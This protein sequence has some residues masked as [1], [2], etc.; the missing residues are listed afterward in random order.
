MAQ[1]KPEKSLKLIER[2]I[3]LLIMSSSEMHPMTLLMRFISGFLYWLAGYHEKALEI[4]EQVLDARKKVIGD[5]SHFTLDSYSTCG[6]LLTEK[7][8]YNNARYVFPLF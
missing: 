8:D 1:Q 5:F 2:C 4:N 7:G 3:E 6:R